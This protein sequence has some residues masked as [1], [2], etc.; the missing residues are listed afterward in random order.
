MPD[1]DKNAFSPEEIDAFAVERRWSVP[2]ELPAGVFLA[3]GDP[4]IPPASEGRPALQAHLERLS[5][6]L[7]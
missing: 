6:D 7:H 3:G 4:G 1:R 5:T 2:G